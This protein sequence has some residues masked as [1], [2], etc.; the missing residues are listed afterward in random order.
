M[1]DYPAVPGRGEITDAARVYPGDGVAALKPL[2]R[3]LSA[4]GFRVMLSLE[5]FNRKYWQ[6]DPLAVAR[7]GLGKMRALVEGIRAV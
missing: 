2:L 5:L 1:N 7:M 6:Q 4:G 3:D